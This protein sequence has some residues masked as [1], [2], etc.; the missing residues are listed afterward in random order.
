MA[1]F[2]KM[3]AVVNV[4]AAPLASLAE[5][6]QQA[7]VTPARPP[8]GVNDNRHPPLKP[9]GPCVSWGPD[10]KMEALR[11]L[12]AGMCKERPCTRVGSPSMAAPCTGHGVR[13]SRGRELPPTE[14][15]AGDAF[16]LGVL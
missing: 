12:Q 2:V 13:G 3:A 7:P 10:Q 16:I 8:Q 1:A 6:V 11:L 15:S 5:A 14:G 9:A 4:R